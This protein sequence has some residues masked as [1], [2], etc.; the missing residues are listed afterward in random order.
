MCWEIGQAMAV[1]ICHNPHTQYHVLV[2]SDDGCHYICYPDKLECFA[3]C[4]NGEEQVGQPVVV[5]T[6]SQEQVV[7]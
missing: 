2:Q 4:Q 3:L 5:D 7:A 6:A 1:D